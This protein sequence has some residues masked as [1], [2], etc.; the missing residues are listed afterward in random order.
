MTD[1]MLLLPLPLILLGWVIGGGSPGPA[2]L[3][4]SGTSMQ[5]GRR[6]GLTVAAGIVVGSACWGITAALGFSAIMMNNAWLFE[7]IRYLG[8][9]YLMYL[10]LKSLRSAW[11]GGE[12]KIPP[13]AARKLFLKGLM[14]HLTNPKAVLG[15]G[16]IYAIALAPGAGPASVWSLFAA[17]ICASSFVF[18]GY[19]ILFSAAPIARAYTRAKRGFEAAFG[20]LFAFASL[21]ILTAR[22]A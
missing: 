21:K 17:L 13:V 5:L 15:W 20:L 18:F 3:A 8:A 10:A 2:T 12:V 7:V 16:A 19:A 1:T 14:L 9:A 11:R 22:L 6:A 4:I